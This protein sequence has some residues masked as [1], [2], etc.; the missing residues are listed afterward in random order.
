MMTSLKT[1]IK[2]IPGTN[3]LIQAKD[4]RAELQLVRDQFAEFSRLSE[5]KEQRFE[6]DWEQRW[7]CLGDN[8]QT[9][10]FD[11]HYLYHMA[12]A[13]RKIADQ[14]P[15]KHHDFSSHLHF[16]TMVSAFVPTVLYEFRP[17]NLAL[18]RLES[19][20]ADLTNLTFE[21]NTLDSVST[22]H[23]VEHLGLGRY[24]DPISPDADL[25][26]MSE[27]QRVL[28]PGG[29]LYFVVPVGK[30]RLAFNGCR[31][32]GY[33]QI[34]DAFAGLELQE[35]ALVEDDERGGPLLRDADPGLVTKQAYACGCFHLSKPAS[36]PEESRDA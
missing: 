16:S 19:E 11:R 5:G 10:S 33:E 28:A 36:K 8:R 15:A 35:F 14:Q 32:Y 18:D 22:M 24:G 7:I 30:P 9:S 20:V 12:W 1:A 27:L 29:D 23:V 13:A 26:A 6:I 31:V 4:Q 3:R 2:Q 34:I 25:A 17:P 21:D